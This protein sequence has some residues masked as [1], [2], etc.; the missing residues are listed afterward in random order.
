MI[1][2]GQDPDLIEILLTLPGDPDLVQG[3]LHL[4]RNFI[5][6]YFLLF[7]ENINQS[8]I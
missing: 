7:S 1:L 8:D 2:L 5:F 6:I 3:T 4:S